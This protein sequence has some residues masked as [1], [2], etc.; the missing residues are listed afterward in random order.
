MMTLKRILVATDFGEAAEA[1]LAYGRELARTFGAR[2]DVLINNGVYD[3]G[4]CE[5]PTRR[6]D[7]HR[8]A[9]P[10]SGGAAAAGQRR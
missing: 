1:A 9:R 4:V 10:R 7:H 2:L 6:S 3:R 5:R 8:D